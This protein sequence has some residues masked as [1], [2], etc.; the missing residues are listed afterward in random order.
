MKINAEKQNVKEWLDTLSG[1]AA[2]GKGIWQN[3][4]A[5]ASVPARR[6]ASVNLYK[7]DKYTKEGDTVIVPG[8]V[9]SMGKMNHSISIAAL[10]YSAQALAKLKAS[11][12]VILSIGDIVKQKDARLVI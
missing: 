3:A 1:A 12:C 2:S 4:Y 10:E 9:L 5:R 8:K 6:R 7:L 11:K